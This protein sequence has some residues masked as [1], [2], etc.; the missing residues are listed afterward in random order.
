MVLAILNNPDFC[1]P[2]TK[3]LRF[4][5]TFTFFTSVT[6]EYQYERKKRREEKKVINANGIASFTTKQPN[7][8]GN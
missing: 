1:F 5:G 4:S 7:N 2:I 8:C 6:S 3:P